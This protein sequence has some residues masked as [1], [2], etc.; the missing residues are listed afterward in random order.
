MNN[1]VVFD[2]GKVLVDFDYGIA[3]RKIAA[4][5]NLSSAKVEIL[6]QQS[7]L[8]IDYESGRLKRTEFFEQICR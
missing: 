7:P 1:V 8:I 2:L 6:I 5:S 3:A 4:H